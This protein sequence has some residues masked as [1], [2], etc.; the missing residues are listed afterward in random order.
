[1]KSQLTK[2]SSFKRAVKYFTNHLTLKAADDDSEYPTTTTTQ[3]NTQCHS[4]TCT[5]DKNIDT[6]EQEPLHLAN[7]TWRYRP[8]YWLIGGRI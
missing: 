3:N 2:E 4:H 6:F 8:L 1:M 7:T 5:A